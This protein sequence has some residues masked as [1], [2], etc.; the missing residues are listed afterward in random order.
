MTID[1]K[2]ED[3]I[4]IQLIDTIMMCA[5]LLSQRDLTSDDVAEALKDLSNDDD[6]TRLIERAD[7]TDALGTT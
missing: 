2:S 7:Y 5:S 1:C 3:G 6:V 4:T